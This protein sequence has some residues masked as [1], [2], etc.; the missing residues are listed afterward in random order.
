MD[1]AFWELW[2]EGVDTLCWYLMVDA[3]PVPSYATSYQSGLYYRNG[4]PK[5]GLQAFR[6]PFVVQSIGHGRWQ[7]WGIT[8]DSGKVLVQRRVGSSW[9]T[10]FE[11][12]RRAHAIFARTIGD[13]GHAPMRARVGSEDS[14][15][16]SP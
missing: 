10:L 4:K 12:R 6:F 15:S 16:F 8:P 1:Q 13:P 5:S 14:L 9:K 3:P 7:V 11:V 2:R